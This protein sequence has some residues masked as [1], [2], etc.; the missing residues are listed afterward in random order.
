M[1]TAALLK[2]LKDPE[3]P[4]N[5]DDLVQA[6]DIEL[7]E[8]GHDQIPRVETAGLNDEANEAFRAQRPFARDK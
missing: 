3:P 1:Y 5:Y 8:L 6:I 4:K 7:K 2:V